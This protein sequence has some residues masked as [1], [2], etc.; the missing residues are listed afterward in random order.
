MY[1]LTLTL[2]DGKGQPIKILID[3]M[4]DRIKM[5]NEETGN[6]LISEH[7]LAPTPEDFD[8]ENGVY[9]FKLKEGVIPEGK[10]KVIGLILIDRKEVGRIEIKR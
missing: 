10:T 7:I 8:E 1:L 3:E 2:K 6:T 9:K 5:V 4:N